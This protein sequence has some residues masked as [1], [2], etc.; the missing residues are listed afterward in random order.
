MF[1]IVNANDLGSNQWLN[2]FLLIAALFRVY[3][4]IIKFDF[5]ALPL[6]RGMFQGDEDRARKF[7]R[8]GL[9]LSLGYIVL[10]APFTL[11]A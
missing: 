8:S 3:L 9:F 7:H 5:A 4:E 11:F 10:S 1:D 2:I 6:T